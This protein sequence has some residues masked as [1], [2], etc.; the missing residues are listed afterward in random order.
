MKKEDAETF[1]PY[2]RDGTSRPGNRK[3][4][5]EAAEAAFLSRATSL[6]FEVAKPWG[7]SSQ[8]DFIVHSGSRCWRVQVK[9]AGKRSQSGYTIHP[10]GRRGIYTKD[11]VDFLAVHIVPFSAW[12]IVPVEV[13]PGTND[14]Y[15]HPR[16][17]N[18]S[19]MDVYREAWCLMAC[20][21]DGICNR[22]ISVWRRC[23]AREGGECPFR[24]GD[25]TRLLEPMRRVTQKLTFDAISRS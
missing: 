11:D 16:R 17:G 22:E 2:L 10:S 5:G 1:A 7:D 15:F 20:P 24:S 6:G 14:L 12:Y 21:R 18:R 23:L 19:R 8:F 13:V 4:D 25:C 9:S 3:R